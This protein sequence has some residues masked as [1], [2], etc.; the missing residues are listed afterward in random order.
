MKAR[1]FCEDNN[2]FEIEV[3]VQKKRG[4]TIAS[5]P[6]EIIGD[7]VKHIDF[8]YDYFNASCGDDGYFVTDNGTNG[9]FLTK[10]IKRE[11]CE[12]IQEQAFHGCYG[13]N[14]GK[15]GIFAIVTGMRCDYGMVLGVK[16]GKYYTYP[17]FYIDGDKM[18]EDICVEF[19]DLEDASYSEM[20]KIY[21]EYQITRCGCRPLGERVKS[22]SRLRKSINSIGVRVRQAWKPVPSPIEY[23][24]AQNEPELHVACTFDRVGDIVDSFKQVGIDDAELCLVGWNSG[25]HDG[26]FP[27]ILPVEPKLGGEE[28]LKK[29]IKKTKEYGYSIVCHDD[30]TAA[31]TIADCFDEEYL[32]KNKDG[33]L[34]KRPCCWSGGRPHKI[35][36]KREYERFEISNQKIIKELGFEGLHYI[37]VMTIL[38]LLK[39]YDKKHP[40]TRKETAEWYRKIMKLSRENFGGFSSEGAY[41]FAASDTDYVLYTM[42]KTEPDETIP[43]CDRIIPFWQIVYHGIILYNAATFTLNYA[44][45]SVKN[46]LKFFEFGGRPQ[47]CYYANFASG[48][49]WMGVEDFL[50]DTERQLSE[51]AEMAKVM[52]DDYELLAPERYEFIDNHEE[53]ADGVFVT[54]YSNGTKVTVDYNREEIKIKRGIY[55]DKVV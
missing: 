46:R 34:H 31:Y 32:L 54:T 22:D 7:N 1:C 29:L 16:N 47:I 24:N 23:Q 3:N 26:R 28:K 50:C 42:F 13:W 39:C 18:Y 4:I 55:E 14:K 10:F 27:Q 8:L 25:G 40:L 51:C 21:R 53:V 12:S 33:S 17:R 5:L 37:D 15:D 2:V 35:C 49:N 38:P 41:D 30:A 36:A 6:L 43:L 20:A 44:A 9:V 52:A 11:S 48:N 45:K 19:Y